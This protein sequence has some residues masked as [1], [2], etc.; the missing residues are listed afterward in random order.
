MTVTVYLR[1]SK[2]GFYGRWGGGCG[3][4]SGTKRTWASYLLIQIV[5][6]KVLLDHA[7]IFVEFDTK[8]CYKREVN[9]LPFLKMV[10]GKIQAIVE[11]EIT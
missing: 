11:C 2:D 8:C 10:L 3:F 1:L 5:Q 7:A 4:Q 6:S 9:C